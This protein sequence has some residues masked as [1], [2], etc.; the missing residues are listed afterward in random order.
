MILE[1]IREAALQAGEIMRTAHNSNDADQ[2][3]GGHSNF[4]TIYDK[5]I[6]L[7]LM[8]KLSEILP[9][10]NFLGEEEGKDVF[11]EDYKKGY[12]FVIDPIDGTS[13]FMHGYGASVTSIGLLKDGKPYIGVVYNPWSD[14]MFYAERGKGAFENGKPIHTSDEPLSLSLVTFGTAAYYPEMHRP[15]FELGYKYLPKC[16][17]IRR[18]GSAAWDICMVAGG[19]TGLYVEPVIQIWDYAAGA[20]ILLEAGGT[21]TDLNGDEV[22]FEGPSAVAAASAGVAREVYLPGELFDFSM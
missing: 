9:E 2:V 17:D 16:V 7:F 1:A 6:Q 10:A 8:D 13:N 22:S 14:Q 20:A 18:S 3:K 5:K 11:K 21:F 15:A 19:R 12:T 4:V